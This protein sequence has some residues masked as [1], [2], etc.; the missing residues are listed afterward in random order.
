MVTGGTTGTEQELPKQISPYNPLSRIRLS[1]LNCQAQSRGS[2]SNRFLFFCVNETSN[3]TVV[4]QPGPFCLP[5]NTWTC[6]A[7]DIL[8]VTPDSG[9]AI[10]IQ[11]AE[12]GYATKH[13]PVH[14]TGLY[15]RWHLC[16]GGKKNKMYFKTV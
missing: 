7:R 6:L 8:V 2:Q 1:K 10:G 4:F 12:A 9:N 15:K 11:W 16:Q 3:G 13:P 14:R 5:E